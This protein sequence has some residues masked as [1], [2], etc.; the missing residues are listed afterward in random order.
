MKIVEFCGPPGAGKTQLM[1]SLHKRLEQAGLRVVRSNQLL[2]STSVNNPVPT[3]AERFEREYPQIA[4]DIRSLIGPS[5][6]KQASL[7]HTGMAHWA[8][9]QQDGAEHDLVFIDEGLLQRNAYLAHAGGTLDRYA[10]LM[11][12]QPVPDVLFHVAVPIEV[13]AERVI[14]RMPPERRA[15]R[16]KRVE[17]EQERNE[18]VRSMM[19]EGLDIYIARDVTVIELD[20]TRPAERLVRRAWR[21]F[22]RTGQVP[23]DPFQIP[24]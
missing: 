19:R 16:Q 4:R 13:G 11:R 12:R 5:K 3:Y 10:D 18:I 23:A 20:G 2:R 6:S 1:V 22:R 8:L 15:A 21:H 9:A 24:A 7:T 14:N 17:R